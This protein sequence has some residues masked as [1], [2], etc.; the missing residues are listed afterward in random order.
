MKTFN[1]NLQWTFATVQDNTPVVIDLPSEWGHS[2]VK[3]NTSL[4]L[5]RRERRYKLRD[6]VTIM[7]TPIVRVQRSAGNYYHE[8]FKVHIWTTE[9]ARWIN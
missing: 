6:R 8:V 2:T 1:E 5:T 7:I 3:Q 9:A 4:S